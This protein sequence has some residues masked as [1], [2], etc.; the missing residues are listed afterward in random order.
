MAR[1]FWFLAGIGMGTVGGLLYAPRS[2]QELREALR[3]KAEAGRDFLR[4]RAGRA[5]EQANEWVERG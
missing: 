1:L 4:D 5:R 3:S 2:G